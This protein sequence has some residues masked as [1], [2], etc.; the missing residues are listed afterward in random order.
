MAD[1]EKAN[2]AKAMA[3]LASE[4]SVGDG[5]FQTAVSALAKAMGCR[6]A[7]IAG[8]SDD[9][10]SLRSLELVATRDD[11]LMVRFPLEGAPA[12]SLYSEPSGSPLHIVG[13]LAERFPKYNALLDFSAHRYC[14][15][16]FQHADG[17]PAGHIFILDDGVVERGDEAWAFFDLIRKRVGAEYTLRGGFAE[18]D[19]LDALVDETSTGLVVT[20]VEGRIVHANKTYTLWSGVKSE[21]EIIGSNVRDWISPGAWAVNEQAVAELVRSGVAE[22]YESELIDRKGRGRQVAVVA[23]RQRTP[24]GI[25][26]VALVRDIKKRK[27]AE[28]ARLESEARFRNLIEGSLEAVLIADTQMQSLFVNPAAADIFGFDSP[29]EILTMASNKSLVAP[30]EMPGILEWRQQIL[31]G[32]EADIEREV[33]GRRKDGSPVWLRVMA[34]LIDWD[35]QPAVQSTMLDITERHRADEARAEMDARFHAILDNVPV[36]MALKD[37]DGCYLLINKCMERRIGYG[38]EALRGKTILEALGSEEAAQALEIERQVMRTGIADTREEVSPYAL[39]MEIMQTTRFPIFDRNGQVTGTGAISLDITEQRQAEGALRESDAHLRAVFENAPVAIALKDLQG[40]YLLVNKSTEAWTGLDNDE[41]RSR[42]V[43]EIR[44]TPDSARAHATDMEVVKTGNVITTEDV[45]AY[46]RPENI[47]HTIRFPVV[48][49]DGK[50]AGMG[51]MS[52]DITEQRQAEMALRESEARLKAVIENAPFAIILK[53]AKGRYATMNR[54]AED[55]TGTT[56]AKAAGKLPEA[57]FSAGLATSE[58][59]RDL[60]VLKYGRIISY[61]MKGEGEY[62]GHTF[63]VTKFPILG[64]SGEPAGLG[65]ITSD[66]SDRKRSEQVLLRQMEKAEES[67]DAK[68]RFL[69]AASH[70]LRQP[71][72]SMELMLEILARQLT[73]PGQQELVSDIVQAANIAAGLLNPLLDFSRLEAGM[74]DAEIVDF[75]VV[76]LLRDMDVGFRSQAAEADLEL[77]IMP[78]SATI[79]SDPVLLSRIVSNFLSNAIRYTEEGRILLGCRRVGDAL[80]IEVWDMG[81]GIDGAHLNSIFEEFHQVESTK[82]DRDQGL[83][84]GL[85][86][87]KAQATLL[88]HEVRVRS[89]PGRGSTFAIEVPM[90]K[91]ADDADSTATKAAEPTAT[92][93]LDGLRMLILEDDAAILRATKAL[94]ERWGCTVATAASQ[95]EAMNVIDREEMMFDLLIA[96]YHLENNENGV[97]TVVQMQDR[98]DYD[99]PAIIVTADISSESLQHVMDNDF[100]LLQKPFRPAAL[101]SAI[102][103]LILDRA[104]GV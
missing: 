81:P 84:L 31:A 57:L 55:W 82:R 24:A 41:M 87:V 50:V 44:Q 29:D 98:L 37:T 99:V 16:L 103:Q 85:A 23:S 62:S 101:R 6:A 26:F 58:R 27:N 7:G 21:S 30:H 18:V 40:R 72:H 78:C 4:A 97:D 54:Q 91:P 65:T 48:D 33:E 36:S 77:R 96:D 3:M 32:E 80:R 95:E 53:D 13:D 52:Q 56:L 93:S 25:R 47:K 75:P 51:A 88:N 9:G 64:Q 71:L 8:L 70:D 46:G 5:F 69:A 15:A 102:A 86:I 76:S 61:E 74:E 42:T 100:P 28:R 104:E 34:R 20:D 11:A 2:I 45:S 68:T 14:A 79:R 66:I 1:S 17:S 12:E 43:H 73:D 22:E 19:W 38:L 67:S 90:T 83:G 92:E 60:E 59:N 35:G 63:W 49:K 10:K 89:R 39:T 94:L